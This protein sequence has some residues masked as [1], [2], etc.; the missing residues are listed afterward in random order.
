MKMYVL[1]YCWRFSA[2]V[3]TGGGAHPVSCTV[4]TGSFP[5]WSG[6]GV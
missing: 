6:L 2:H 4:G 3:Q 5:G 1:L